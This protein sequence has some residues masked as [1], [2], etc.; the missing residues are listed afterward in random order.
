[1]VRGARHDLS[2]RDSQRWEMEDYEIEAA[3]SEDATMPLLCTAPLTSCCPS[4]FSS[5]GGSEEEHE[6][7]DTRSRNQLERSGGCWSSVPS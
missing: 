2:A 6:D 7:D 4:A 1:M 3:A 5:N